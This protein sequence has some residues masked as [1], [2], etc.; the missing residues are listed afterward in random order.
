MKKTGF[1]VWRIGA[2]I[3]LQNNWKYRQIF[4]LPG[5]VVEGVNGN[6]AYVDFELKLFFISIGLR[7]I[8]IK[9][10]SSIFVST[11]KKIINERNY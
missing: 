9:K 3:Y 6:D 7:F 4:L 5:L 10:K 2:Y 1:H 8:W 11:L